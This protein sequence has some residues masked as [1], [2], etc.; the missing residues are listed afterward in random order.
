[1]KR[2]QPSEN[3]ADAFLA[4]N[5]STL[6]VQL[7]REELKKL[8][9]PNAVLT[10]RDALTRCTANASMFLEQAEEWC[11]VLGYDSF[12]RR[13]T[14]LRKPPLPEAFWLSRESESKEIEAVPGAPIDLKA[15]EFPSSIT[16]ADAAAIHIEL[17]KRTGIA[18]SRNDTDA[19]LLQA[20]RHNRTYN[21]VQEFLRG[22]RWD[23]EGRLE[24]WLIDLADA[25]DTLYVRMVSK[26]WLIS[27]VAR[28]MKPGCKVDHALVL[29]GE[30][31]MKKSLAFRVLGYPWSIDH[32]PDLANKD[33]ALQLQGTW[34]V[35]LS[36]LAAVVGSS[37]IERMKAF[38]TTPVDRYRAPYAK[39]SDDHPRTC[40][41]AGTINPTGG[42]YILD[43]TGGRH[44]W[45][46][47]CNKFFDIDKLW[48]IREA[49]W[50]EAYMAYE[51]GDRWWPETAEEAGD[52]TRE[53][54]ERLEQ[55]SFEPQIRAYL[56]G[57]EFIQ[58]SEILEHAL[59]IEDRSRWR[60]DIQQR[61]RA[62]LLRLGCKADR[63]RIDGHPVRGYRVSPELS[64]LS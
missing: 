39:T 27:A 2:S 3:K 11:G 25:K 5:A 56:A 58:V 49:L 6:T 37:S 19:A 45:P 38:F 4:E 17:Q 46:V 16:E 22:A 53:Q 21:P 48:A 36:E 7:P 28:A 42:G 29:E 20:A 31:G 15:S 54:A 30:Q 55:D 33:A 14:F 63:K 23:N 40:V 12:A 59:K 61:V 41:F 43:P 62:C 26:M 10:D 64:D 13:P 32:V 1:M 9:G 51:R 34:I 50:A 47:R 8:L 57:K 52:A 44:F 18:F 24:T 35:E 60:H